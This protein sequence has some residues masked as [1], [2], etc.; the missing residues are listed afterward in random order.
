MIRCIFPHMAK[1]RLQDFMDIA[2][3]LA[4]ESRV[5]TL[6]ALKQGELCVCQITEILD[7]APS[8]VSKHMALL[9]QARLVDSR[10]E[11]R[12][13]YYRLPDDPSPVVKQALEWVSGSLE[14]AMEITHDRKHLEEIVGLE[15]EALCQL[16]RSRP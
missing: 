10:K 3:A 2:R 6:L 15:P 11:G 16:Q 5:R 8:T 7:L 4:D 9:R 14:E 12:W 13:I 1:Y